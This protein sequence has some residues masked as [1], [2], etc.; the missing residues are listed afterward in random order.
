MH[1]EDMAILKSLV[2][3]A[4]VDGRIAGEEAEHI[5]ALINA[6]G[7]SDTEAEQVREFAKTPRTLGDIPITEMSADDRRT[8]LNHAVVLTYI[9]GEQ[10]TEEKA[11]IGDLR[12]QLRI[13][14]AEASRIIEAAEARVKRLLQLSA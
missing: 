12:D 10:S 7:A 8:L 13:P 14:E 11:L 3:V 6:F 1:E 5:E 2:V 9:D 4:W